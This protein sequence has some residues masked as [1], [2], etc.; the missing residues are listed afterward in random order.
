VDAFAFVLSA[1]PPPPAR[2]LEVGCG[3]GDLARALDA[4]GFGVLAIDPQAP[5]GPIFSRTTLEDLD[6]AGQFEAALARYSLHHIESLDRAL[7]RISGLLEPEG[8]LVVEEFGWDRLDEASAKWY[9]QQQ[10][11]PSVESVLADWNEEHAGLHGYAEMR[12]ALDER[13]NEDFFEW[14]PYLYRCLERDDLEPSEREAIA[15][16]EIRAVG[17]RYVGS[18]RHATPGTGRSTL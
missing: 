8:R 1:L 3:A 17:F 15:G 11:E 12:P 4:A 2:L 6:E 10:G 5:E 18:L 14:Q 9:G 7:D 16:A 13:F